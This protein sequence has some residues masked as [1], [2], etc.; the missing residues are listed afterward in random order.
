MS[1]GR[2]LWVDC[3]AGLLVGVVVFWFG[4]WFGGFYG[5]PVG[6]VRFIAGVNVA[7]GLFSLWLVRL[8]VRSLFLIGFLVMANVVWAVLC[9][10]WV[11]VWWGKAS[12]F[13][14]AHFVLEGLFVAGLA[15]FEWRWREV[16]RVAEG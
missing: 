12:V 1:R 2:V 10:R 11:F 9:A 7:Y 15:F 16:L 8:R 5:L 3:G 4:G 14:L 13:G 6:F